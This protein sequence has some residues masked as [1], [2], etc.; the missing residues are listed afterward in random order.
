MVKLKAIKLHIELNDIEPPIWRDVLLPQDLTLGELHEVI[1]TAMGWEDYHLHEFSK[2]KQ[3]FGPPNEFE[4]DPKLVD[5]DEVFVDEIFLRKGSRLSYLYDFGDDWSHRLVSLGKVEV[6]VDQ[7]LP[8]F[9]DGARACPPEDIGGPWSYQAI[10]DDFAEGPGTDALPPHIR[11]WLGEDFDPESFDSAAIAQAVERIARRALEPEFY[12]E[13]ELDID[14]EAWLDQDEN[15]RLD[16]VFAYHMDHAEEFGFDDAGLDLD[17]VDDTDFQDSQV[18]LS[19]HSALH[20]F[21]E[22]QLAMN[23]PPEVGSALRR[24]RGQGLTRHDALHAIAWNFQKQFLVPQFEQPEI[25]QDLSKYRRTLRSLSAKQWLA[26]TGA[27]QATLQLVPDHA[28]PVADPPMHRPVE[29]AVAAKVG[30]N[31]PCPCGSGKKYKKCCLNKD[32]RPSPEARAASLHQLDNALVNRIGMQ[33][34]SWDDFW[35]AFDAWFQDAGG[36][37]DMTQLSI[38]AAMYLFRFDGETGAERVLRRRRGKLSEAEISWLRSQGS[39]WLGVWEVQTVIPGQQVELVDLLSGERRQVIE[40]KGSVALHPRDCILAR[41][42]DHQ[43]LSLFVG[44]HAQPLPPREASL[45][46][47]SLC[48][49]F[50]VEAGAWPLPRLFEAEI[51]AALLSLWAQ[52]CTALMERPL[53]ELENT[54]GEP[55]LLTRDHFSVDKGQQDALLKKLLALDE[56]ELYVRLDGNGDDASL[57]HLVFL[58]DGNDKHESW[59]N[60]L[61]A[62]AVLKPGALEIETNSLSRA[63]QVRERV[64]RQAGD[65]CQHRAR[66]HKDPQVMMRDAMKKPGAGF[67]GAHDDVP[68]PP[69]ISAHLQDYKRKHYTSWL[70]MAIPALNGSTPRQASQDPAQRPA[71]DLLLKDLERSEAMLPVAERFDMRS[72]RVELGL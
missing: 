21:I 49:S 72:L 55:L 51:S 17:A 42:V 19:V 53:P 33:G 24:L 43:G 11:E 57:T 47:Q 16:A 34:H 65:L 10:L 50:D 68:L 56:P 32:Q 66:T 44:S 63:D 7:L 70:D 20:G 1:Q 67:Q 58:R 61:I 69:E 46:V 30:R 31:D 29:R 39:A 54:D 8:S 22:N 13:P 5:E 4:P 12:Y 3:R 38:P 41:V 45:V 26:Q 71:L 27:D 9:L 15:T 35:R 18:A 37:L 23:D 64:L 14:P 28:A 59:D 2:G 62:H 6:Q 48:S 36:D 40:K 52:A 25:E 60:T